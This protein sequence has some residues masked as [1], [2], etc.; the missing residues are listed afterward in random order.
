MKVVI[1]KDIPFLAGVLDRHATVVSRAGS[2]IT[3]NDV[4]DADALIVRTRTLCNAGLLQGTKVRFI[5]S[6]TIGFDHIDTKFCEANGV[7]WTNA[8]GCNSSSVQQY[9]AAALFHL[10][11]KLDVE[12]ARTTIGIVGVGN[13][14]SKIARFCSAIGM[15]V[16]LNDPPR[17]RRE[18]KGDFVPLETVVAESDILTFHV[19]LNRDGPDKTVHLIDRQ[20]LSKMNPRQIL[21][22]TSRGEVADTA[23]LK[24][25]LRTRSLAAA[26]VDVWEDEPAIDT[27]LLN[28]VTIGTP[29]I[30]GYSADGKANGTAMSVRALSRYFHLGMDTWFPDGVPE[31]GDPVIALDCAGLKRQK[32]FCKLVTRTYD[33]LADDQRLRNSPASFE[34]QRAAYPL[35]REFP[36]YKVKLSNTTKDIIS[37]VQ[38]LG[39]QIH[40]EDEQ[41]TRS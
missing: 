12:L 37:T 13:V 20:M 32:V 7:Q 29:H 36:A 22:N 38:S 30:A 6:A 4:Q 33:I 16:L 28:L 17:E 39:F 24:S 10:S 15:R 41:Y 1:D 8:A 26:V 5:A 19:P 31:P 18:G 35:R 9:V 11:N 14:G 3:K 21:I 2:A 23:A 34:H 40:D 27:D 25:A